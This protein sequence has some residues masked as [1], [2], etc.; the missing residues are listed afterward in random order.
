MANFPTTVAPAYGASKNS[1]PIIRV[2]VFGSGYS[3][4]STIGI[5]Q[6]L[7]T[8]NFEWRNIS[9]TTADEIETFLEARGGYESFSYQPTGESAARKYICAEWNKTIPYLNRANISATFIQ[10]AEP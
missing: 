8:W 4:R 7:K 2:A 3:Q 1:K 9:E 6:D 10:V 5:N